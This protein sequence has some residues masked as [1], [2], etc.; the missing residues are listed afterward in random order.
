MS[1]NPLTADLLPDPCRLREYAS[2]DG[3]TRSVN[4]PIFRKTSPSTITADVWFD[5]GCPWCFIGKRRF[6][7]AIE[8]FG[9]DH[10]GVAVEVDH[11][12]FQLAPSLPERFH[13]T[14]AEYLQSYEG[15]PIAHV[16]QRLSNVRDIAASEGIE[17]RFD[18]LQLVNTRRAHRVFQFGRAHGVGE[19]LLD[20]LFTAYFSECRDLND[21]DVL[22]GLAAEVGLDH[23]AAR[24]AASTPGVGDD[25]ATVGA[26]HW[27]EAVSLDCAS[28]Q[29]LGSTGVPFTVFD[30]KYRAGGAQSPEVFAEALDRVL[31]LRHADVPAGRGGRS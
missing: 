8:L 11:R 21:P 20:R 19:E 18:D 7:R 9:Q 13:G 1:L 12:S 5:V 2:G 26:A 3:V 27:D 23:A 31:E 16:Q 28:A 17:L 6:E 15:V 14:V 4:D 25:G 24:A 22:A 29:T 30:G 10:P